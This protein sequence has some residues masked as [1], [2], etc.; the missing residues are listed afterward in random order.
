[1]SKPCIRIDRET[2]NAMQ[3]PVVVEGWRHIMPM[4]GKRKLWFA[5]FSSHLERIRASVWHQK[6]YDWYLVSGTPESLKLEQNTYVWLTTRL[7]PFF[8]MM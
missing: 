2:I 7:I 8:G 3:Y 1:M 5:E 4:G 6:F